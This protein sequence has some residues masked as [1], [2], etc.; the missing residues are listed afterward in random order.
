MGARYVLSPMALPRKHLVLSPRCLA[1]AVLVPTG[2]RFWCRTFIGTVLVSIIV[3]NIISPLEKY[4]C[5]WLISKAV[6][7]LGLS[8]SGSDLEESGMAG[9]ALRRLLP[10]ELNEES[11]SDL[12][13]SVMDGSMFR[14]CLPQEWKDKFVKHVTEYCPEP[15]DDENFQI[16]IGKADIPDGL[17]YE[18]GSEGPENDVVTAE[19]NLFT[20]HVE[21]DRKNDHSFKFIRLSLD[22]LITGV[23]NRYWGDDINAELNDADSDIRDFIFDEKTFEVGRDGILSIF[24]CSGRYAVVIV[25]EKHFAFVDFLTDDYSFSADSPYS[26]DFCCVDV[27]LVSLLQGSD[28]VNLFMQ[29]VEAG[30]KDE[31]DVETRDFQLPEI[32]EKLKHLMMSQHP[33]LGNESG[34]KNIPD[35]LIRD[36]IRPHLLNS[37]K[38]SLVQLGEY[39]A[40]LASGYHPAPPVYEGAKFCL[41]CKK[42]M[43]AVGL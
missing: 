42:K 27:Q 1:A 7:L 33:R 8:M 41:L 10:H 15:C 18:G 32:S 9:P 17:K 34:L 16:H 25:F 11:G 29:E 31:W 19:L 12:E 13:E 21:G 36:A 5:T 2:T 37:Q 23:E 30:E 22:I 39:L 14:R 26:H 38:L 20:S 35:H 43:P 40:S 28:T 3:K 24:S 4:I 6:G